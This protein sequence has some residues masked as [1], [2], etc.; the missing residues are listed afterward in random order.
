MGF[1]GRTIGDQGLESVDERIGV[2]EHKVL[3]EVNPL[4]VR[5]FRRTEEDTQAIPD[6][7]GSA[8]ESTGCHRRTLRDHR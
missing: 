7:L 3:D 6:R 5:I 4:H 8:P 2:P 1:D